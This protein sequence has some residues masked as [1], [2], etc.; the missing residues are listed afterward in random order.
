MKSS[1]WRGELNWNVIYLILLNKIVFKFGKCCYV[2]CYVMLP[3]SL[4][5]DVPSDTD[6]S[7]EK[8]I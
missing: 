5:F 7:S 6:S 1:D 3:K 2:C 4:L 8:C